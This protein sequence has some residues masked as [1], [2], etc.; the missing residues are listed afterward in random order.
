MNYPRLA[1]IGFFLTQT[2]LQSIAQHKNSIGVQLV[3][4]KAGTFAMTAC[5]E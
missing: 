3:D 5:L 1:L 4:V 2:G